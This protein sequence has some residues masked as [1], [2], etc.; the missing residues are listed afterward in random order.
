MSE[1]ALSEVDGEMTERRAEWID[2]VRRFVRTPS[3]N[4]PGETTAVAAELTDLL[5]DAGIPYRVIAPRPEMPNVVAQFDGERGDPD[6]GRHLTFNGHLDTFPATGG[7]DWDRDPFAGTVADGRIYG[8]GVADMYGGLTAS[9][10]ATRFLFENRDRFRGRV[11]FAAVSDEETGGRWG[12]EYLV[13]EHPEYTGD[14]VI[15][16]E[17]SSNGVVRFA[18][19]GILWAEATIRGTADHV[20]MAGEKVSAVDVLAELVVELNRQDGLADLGEM[21]AEVAARIRDA[22]DALDGA[23]GEGVTD[24]VL[25]PDLNVGVVEG[26]EKANLVAEH[27]RAEVDVRLPVGSATADAL[28]WL[29]AT[30]A[31]YPAAIDVAPLVKQDPTYSDPGDPVFDCLVSAAERVRGTAPKL[32]CSL[33]GT[34]CRFYRAVGVPC[35]VYG[36]T[37]QHVGGA[38]ENVRIEEFLEVVRAQAMAA[39]DYLQGGGTAG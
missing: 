28:A 12:T 24:R 18:E 4:P 11:T 32:S 21:P 22:R 38:N 39:V 9:L 37:G 23:K 17:P 8:R 1:I 33:G 19:R 14:A 35:A 20:S 16:G 6:A 30:V 34:D 31:D 36:P 5:D 10:A 29:R 3:E 26:G 27:A 25:R 13:D 7:D 2:A 15:N